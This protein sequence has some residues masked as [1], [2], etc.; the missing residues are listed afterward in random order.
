MNNMN[1]MYVDCR[2]VVERAPG[3]ATLGLGPV[4]I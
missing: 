2:N 1:I 4:S 3:C